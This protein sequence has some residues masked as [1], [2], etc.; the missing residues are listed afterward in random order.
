MK[1]I[2]KIRLQGEPMNIAKPKHQT[3]ITVIGTATL[4]NFLFSK[5][6]K[7]KCDSKAC[8]EHLILGK[9]YDLSNMVQVTG[10]NCTNVAIT[11]SRFG[12]RNIDIICALGDDPAGRA[13]ASEMISEGINVSRIIRN[14]TFTTSQSTILVAPG[15]ERTILNYRGTDIKTLQSELGISR[16]ESNWIY[17]SSVNSP[18]MI[19]SLMMHARDNNIKL[20]FNPSSWETAN[21]P[22]I[23]K[24]L[25]HI[26][27]MFLNKEEAMEFFNTHETNISKL[28]KMGAES[29]IKYFVIT[30]GPKGS[31]LIHDAKI[32]KCGLYK[33]VEVVERTGAGDAFASGFLSIIATGGDIEE[34][35]TFGAANSTSVVQHVGGKQGI[36][37]SPTKLERMP[38]K[39]EEV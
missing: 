26:E 8:Y 18:K 24:F 30:D 20:A 4:D 6:F 35:L 38:I 36:L 22:Q 1:S 9:K 15:G 10:G 12:I 37:R 17:L 5:A 33:D 11:L 29:G 31:A 39:V 2:N 7:P 21:T 34:A 23:K 28:L 32:Y 16:I 3:S 13:V 14:Q 27:M 19:L 25:N